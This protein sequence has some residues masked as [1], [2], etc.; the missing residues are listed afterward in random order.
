MQAGLSQ[1]QSEGGWEDSNRKSASNHSASMSATT[2]SG[3]EPVHSRQAATHQ[4][5]ENDA[6]AQDTS[7]L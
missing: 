3:W 6:L 4:D 1:R 2:W 5:N 7:M